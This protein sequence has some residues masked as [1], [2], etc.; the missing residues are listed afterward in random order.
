MTGVFFCPLLLV[1][2]LVAEG[3]AD[4]PGE[5][6]LAQPSYCLDQQLR[7]PLRPYHPQPG[8]IMLATDHSRFWAIAHNL[9]LTGH[10]HHSGIVVALP[11]GQL[12]MLESGPHDTLHV[13][14]LKL[15]PN[16]QAYER[17]GPVWIRQRAVPLTPEQSARLTD[18]A[19]GA[20]GKRFAVL[21]IAV[22]VTPFRT[23]G[24]LRTWFV[25]GP[26]GDRR[27]YF[28]SEVVLEACV[29]ADLLDAK[30]TRPSATFPRELF[31]DRSAN[32]FLDRYFTLAPC[33]EPP[34]RWLSSPCS[35]GDGY[36]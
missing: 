16:L 14:L 20:A 13:E 9:A 31:F 3:K 7:G 15:L 6:Y 5:F 35:S 34:A 24:P 32:P 18:F 8:D 17:E 2:V 11:D 10:P 1:G 27:K 19:L 29:A 22:Q 36:G 12:A 26:H 30:T 28:C 4:S 25:G 23:R 21:R 33:W